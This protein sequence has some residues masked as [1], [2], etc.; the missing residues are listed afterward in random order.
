M[1]CLGTAVYSCSFEINRCLGLQG[2]AFLCSGAW[3]LTKVHGVWLLWL[4]VLVAED[5][6]NGGF[7]RR[8]YRVQVY[9]LGLTLS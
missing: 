1:G 3:G 5:S 9:G 7:A 4:M 2:L 6:I 8:A